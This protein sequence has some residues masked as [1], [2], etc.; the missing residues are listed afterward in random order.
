MYPYPMLLGRGDARESNAMNDITGL[1]A[2]LS[3]LI[4]V[5]GAGIGTVYRPRAMR[6]EAEAKAYEIKVI[7]MAQAEAERIGRG[8]L[9]FDDGRAV[10][11]SNNNESLDLAGRIRS[12]I[13]SREIEAQNNLE[14]IAENAISEL[15]DFVSDEPVSN[16]WRRKFFIEAEHI[17]DAE[18]QKLWGKV[19]AGEVSEPGSYGLRTLDALRGLSKREAELFNVACGLAF[20]DGWIFRPSD[21]VNNALKPYGLDFVSILNLRDVG[22]VSPGDNIVRQFRVQQIDTAIRPTIAWQLGDVILDCSGQSLVHL[23]IP[24]FLLTRV[25]RELRR[26]IRPS[27]N[28]QYV[29]SFVG[30][31]KCHGISYR[32]GRV[33]K[34][35]GGKFEVV[36][37]DCITGKNEGS[38]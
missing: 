17:C 15:P 3:K 25:G 37:E 20:E 22:L 2:P 33:V 1:G 23:D 14:S 34:K 12:R 36:F 29:D 28:E 6:N 26:L 13:M 24:A 31:L 8:E 21:D 19:L 10:S 38:N 4:E 11:C 35:G 18:M 5:I 7:A 9:H 30:W 16:D 32:K 27:A